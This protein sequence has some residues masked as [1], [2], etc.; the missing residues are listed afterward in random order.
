[1]DVEV[2]AV[3]A[4]SF[5]HGASLPEDL[6]ARA[7]SLGLRALALCDRD[8]VA[9]IPRFHRAARAAG[10]RPIVG[11]SVRI[12]H[13]DSV[14]RVALYPR[15]RAGYRA[16]CR[17]LT[18]ARM[19][20]EREVTRA[21][22]LTLP[23]GS[24][25]AIAHEGLSA[26]VLAEGAFARDVGQGDARAREFAAAVASVMPAGDCFLE[27]RRT[28]D[29]A[30]ARIDA[31]IAD[32]SDAL[33][34]RTAATAGPRA[35]T[36]EDTVVA[37][38]FD[39]ARLRCTLEEAGRALEP[40]R[41]RRLKGPAELMA[42]F[43]DAPDARRGAKELAERCAFTLEDLGYAFPELSLPEDTSA[44]E[45]LEQLTRIGARER[46]P[47][48]TE[49]VR[50]Q[51]RHELD[52]IGRLGL[53]GYFLVVWDI[54]R[55]CRE[56]GILVQ[57]RGSA[58]NSAVCYALGITAVDPVGMELLFERFLSEARGEWPD[59]D[60]DLPSGARREEVIQ[61]V[62][63]RYG[64]RGAAM[65]ANVITFR[66][67]SAAREAGTA[68]GFSSDALSAVSKQLGAWGTLD[69]EALSERFALA[70][71]SPRDPRV[72]LWI[73]A[74]AR[75][76]NLPRH[77]GQ[78]PGGMVIAR[79]R[80]DE[81]CPLEPA[82][83]E[84]R[85]IVPW[86]KDD[87]EDLG[88]LKVDL[89]GLGMMALFE[90]VIPLVAAHDGVELDL[91]RIPPDDPE[92]YAMI[93]AADTIG[94]FQ[95]ESRAQMNTLPRLKPAR[96][97][98]LVVQVAIIR[99]GPIV[100]KMVH[101]YLARRAGREPVRY[102]HPALEPVLARTL[103]VPLFQEQLMRVAM[104][105]AGFSGGEAEE[106]R[107]AM[108]S[109]RS[110]DRMN[111]LEIKLRDGMTRNGYPPAAQEDVIRGVLS[112]ALYG[113]P[114]SHSASFAL[115]AYASAYLKRHHPAS[116]ACA[117][118]D[119]WPMGF[120]EPATVVQDARRHGV[121]VLP[122]DVTRSGWLCARE[123][124]AVRLGLRYVRGLGLERGQAIARAREERPFISIGDL[125]RRAGL[126]A[127]ELSTLAQLGA[128]AELP[129]PT[130][131]ARWTRR[132]ALWQSLAVA[133]ADAG[134]LFDDAEIP[135]E[136]S[137][138]PDMTRRERVVADLAHGA[139]TVGAHPVALAREALRAQ[140]VLSIREAH[141]QRDR[142]VISVAGTVITR[143]KPPTAKGFVFLSLEDET[144][145]LNAIVAPDVFASQRAMYVTEPLLIL[146]GILQVQDGVRSVRVVTATPFSIDDEMCH[147]P[148]HD[149]H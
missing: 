126:R 67:R 117:L 90:R 120:Y 10:L 146:Q 93:R 82:A 52:T 118:L 114:E 28:L 148:S 108:G 62:Y 129:H 139:L 104:V 131:G 132:G 42:L 122:V 47:S 34:L 78:H 40:N 92:T 21:L 1:M 96:F 9:G 110:I 102:P 87:C 124:P 145:I 105:A 12:A 133:R 32:L 83:M 115:L 65:T 58:A 6:C 64:E 26:L 56:R 54:V 142:S 14:S 15:T 59:I 134:P 85:V 35:A 119:C 113:F 53:A 130:P 8:G 68:L 74:T 55:F 51:L 81:L 31:R 24:L 116:F 11:T 101:P 97:Y 7:A 61:Y 57:G 121:R 3:S 149:F 69:R 71:V 4:F 5:L 137:P 88:I 25:R 18:D 20:A 86:D 41:E 84:G 106:L 44:Q 127:R 19:T 109:K 46:Y 45:H 128:L 99:P 60:L 140:G 94:V 63:R 17:A 79:G 112:F 13:G 123:G 2:H 136:R 107:R 48:L 23:L 33:G 135:V 29:R 80:L 125:S 89:L 50:A 70:G 30:G 100:G 75:L 43:R 95:I 27:R 98:D 77:L 36:A 66:A 37:D 22:G 76:Q 103:G 91:A 38:L 39:C 143:Q 16:L 144:G 138:L 147:P 49:R 73:D 141:T 72:S 111:A